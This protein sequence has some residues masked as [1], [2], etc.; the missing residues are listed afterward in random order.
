M[1]TLAHQMAKKWAED[2]DLKWFVPLFPSDMDSMGDLWD[3]VELFLD[4]HGPCSC[5][6]GSPGEI[7]FKAVAIGMLNLFVSMKETVAV[8][9]ENHRFVIFIDASVHS[10]PAAGTLLEACITA[11]KVL[12]RLT[13]ITS[14]LVVLSPSSHQDN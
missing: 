4:E 2:M 11:G 6:S 3:A 9:A 10:R 8:G 5:E 13:K 12:C 1:E 14:R 7:C